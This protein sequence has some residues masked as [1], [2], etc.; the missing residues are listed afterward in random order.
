MKPPRSRLRRAALRLL[1]PLALV[2]SLP[3]SGQT[4]GGSLP[5]AEAK[6]DPR[7]TSQTE[8]VLVPVLVQDKK[9]TFVPQLTG[10]AFTLLEDGKP[11]SIAVFEEVRAA[12]EGVS[13]SQRKE[14]EFSNILEQN[15]A[16]KRVVVIALD[17]V[18]TD[19]TDQ[20]KAREQLIA[21]LLESL[22]TGNLTA[23]IK[24]HGR[25][26]TVLH[27]FTAD[28]AVLIEGLKL[29][30][31]KERG[32]L[33][34]M[35]NTKVGA[36]PPTGE[37]L[38]DALMKVLGSGTGDDLAQF[39]NLYDYPAASARQSQAILDTLAGL[40]HIAQSLRGVPGRK[41]LIWLTGSFPLSNDP[42]SDVLHGQAL[43]Y[44]R[45]TLQALNDANVA[46][47]AVD[48]RGL[49]HVGMPDASVHTGRR[50]LS[51]AAELTADA[52]KISDAQAAMVASTSTMEMFAGATGGKAFYNRNDLAGAVRQATEDSSSYYLL[53][54]YLDQDNKREGWRK[55]QVKVR[56]PGVRV[57]ARSGFFA[58]PALASAA[59][60]PETDMNQALQSPLDYTAIPLVIRWL[61]TE[62]NGNK[63]KV[64]FELELPPNADMVAEGN[65]NRLSME[66]AAVAHNAE[67]EDA[68]HAAQSFESRL[69][70]EA[71]A[72]V[73]SN[74]ITYRNLLELAP[75]V[76]T[77]RFVVRD[78]LSGRVGSVGAPLK[79]Q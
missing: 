10:E 51:D 62:A 38:R 8:L 37:A 49:V 50:W 70:P 26:V 30:L 58:T 6:S 47:Y 29:A 57:R 20:A 67:G 73:R 32:Q 72:Q 42:Q 78:N 17:L 76:Y 19:F 28:P 18:N 21:N 63:R 56:H 39:L 44:Y 68:G 23:L 71:L 16:P 9:G 45:R 27:D 24:I 75:G 35:G 53:G 36:K 31:K 13:R 33:P 61:G 2:A 69:G 15:A 48:V 25:G 52:N 66:F 41:S 5:Q 3:A 65:S 54:Y 55:L 64:R 74:G 79:I 34:E 12:A 43:T 60:A 22:G 4:G 1:L 46:V 11:Q 77:V 7:F 40:A 59:R 14:G